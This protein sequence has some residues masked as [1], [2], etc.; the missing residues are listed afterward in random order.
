M[1]Y[2]E[3][4]HIIA[5]G[6]N[7]TVE[8][9]QSFTKAVIETL[10]AFSNTRG[11]SVF[12][13]VSD[14][15]KNIGVS[16]NNETIQKWIN[17]I[18]QNTYPQLIPELETYQIENKTIVLVKVKEFPIKPVSYKNKYFKR[19]KNSNHQMD[20]NEI[21]NEHLKT[22]NSSW[23]F[24]PDP[25]HSLEDI[26]L[27]KVNAYIYKIGERTGQKITEKP[28]EFLKKLEII[29]DN[30]LTFG[31]YLL[32]A[33]EYCA[34]S[35]IQ[36]GRFKS[37]ITIID[38]ISLDTDLFTETEKIMAFIKKHLMVEYIITDKQ[39]ERIERFDYPLDAIREIVIN[40]IVHRDYRD[41]SAS[42]IKI[43]DNR[44][45]F[46]N[47]G[48]LYGDITIHDLLTN[49]YTSKSRNKLVSKAFKEI[50]LI[51]RYGSGI[52]RILNICFD[53]G[54]I[55][56]TFE[57]IHQGLKVVLFKEKLDDVGND[58]GNDV[59]N[60]VG[61]ELSDL[62]KEIIKWI[63]NNNKITITI[64]ASK[65]NRTTRTIERNIEKLKERD[66]IKRIGSR[67][68]GYWKIIK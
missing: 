40:M 65:T 36:I 62:Q 55:A 4:E 11:G 31:A 13:G 43:F 15:K 2:K 46:F 38:S 64:L 51:E 48:E 34:I 47:P 24:Y 16:I 20:L 54:I 56:P 1:P 14:D 63:S 23:D 8:F 10:V 25:N 7:E 5:K 35:D 50:G 37:E 26:S 67:K 21:A 27:D 68:E 66:L 22:I 52:K 61:N 32:F 60:N 45:E 3:L 33:K 28:L 58:I 49:N 44:I 41:S 42:I 29:R 12:I 53:Y 57:V 39:L 19:I 17:E 6:E 59:G 18:K 9:K 30:K